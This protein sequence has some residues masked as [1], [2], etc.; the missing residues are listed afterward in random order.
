MKENPKNTDPADFLKNLFQ[1][2]LDSLPPYQK[3]IYEKLSANTSFQIP[4]ELEADAK[5]LVKRHADNVERSILWHLVHEISR[6]TDPAYA[7]G[8]LIATP[9]NRLGVLSAQSLSQYA[10]RMGLEI[11]PVHRLTRIALRLCR[12]RAPREVKEKI[13][14]L[15]DMGHHLQVK[16][17]TR[18]SYLTV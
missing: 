3:M 17:L 9:E 10:S 12:G 15:P 4:E 2:K 7:L 14:G 8:S 5:R 11:R 6:P 18:A 13:S 16:C 1:H